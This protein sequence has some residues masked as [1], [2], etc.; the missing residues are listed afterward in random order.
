MDKVEGS[1]YVFAID[2]DGTLLNDNGQ[3]SELTRSYLN[4]LNNRIVIITG[5][6]YE[7]A[8]DIVN[9]LDLSSRG[10]RDYLVFDDGSNIHCF[11]ENDV[12]H[13]SLP[14]ISIE[15]CNQIHKFAH[16]YKLDYSIYCEG[17]V[18][19]VINSKENLSLL[20]YRLMVNGINALQRKRTTRIVSGKKAGT[21]FRSQECK[22]IG[23]N[24][25]GS[26]GRDSVFNLFNKTFGN[27]LYYVK[28]DGMIEV[29]NKLTDKMSAVALICEKENIEAD[30][31]VYFGN[32]GNDVACLNFYKNSF[33]VSNA[34]EEAKAAARFLTQYD[35]NNDGVILEIMKGVCL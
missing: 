17:E 18:I 10:N 22:K 13:F 21:L 16:E 35:N 12:E 15:A 24:R 4:S 34:T 9:E 31:I 14:S 19:Q 7:D 27:S 1:K 33:A 28:N 26:L 3:L 25:F 6:N 8:Y 20:V 23:I 32:S 5:R 2:L 30:Q 29:K 11:A